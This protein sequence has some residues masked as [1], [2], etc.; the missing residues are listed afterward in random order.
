MM[1]EF[2]QKH[3]AALIVA[4]VLVS[5][6]GLYTAY[7]KQSKTI[8]PQ[9]LADVIAFKDFSGSMRELNKVAALAGIGLIA[10]CF[11]MGPLSRLFPT[12][13]AH[14][15]VYRK[16]VGIAGFGLALLHSA[17]SLIEFYKLD[18]NRM[19]FA[20]PKLLGFVTAIAALAIFLAMTLTSTAWAV[21]RMGYS[22]WKAL[23]TF[24][25]IGL[26][27]AIIHFIVLETKPDVGL[28]VRPFGLLFLALAII[29]LAVRVG[30]V[31]VKAPERTKFEH[32]I[33]E[34][35]PKEIAKR[36]K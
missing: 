34:E 4:L 12:P 19:L 14:Y 31:F 15:L 32:H 27:F 9:K 1:R 11:L 6:L 25:Y 28:D 17:Y 20:N 3:G 13:F 36:L 7:D 8:M 29:A 26:F 24:G 21:K 30:M 33:G 23:Q 5:L 35:H 2:L 16:S 22:K 18:I 10:I